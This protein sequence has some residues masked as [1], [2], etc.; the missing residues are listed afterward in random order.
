MLL[1]HKH[2]IVRAEIHH[3]PATQAQWTTG[4]AN[5]FKTSA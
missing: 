1:E 3:P 5:W 4:C 2:L